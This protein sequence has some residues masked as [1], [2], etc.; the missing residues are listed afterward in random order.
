MSLQPI[1]VLPAFLWKFK[2][3]LVQTI[4]LSFTL[5]LFFFLGFASNYS[6]GPLNRIPKHLLLVDFNLKATDFN[7]F[8]VKLETWKVFCYILSWH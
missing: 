1:Y 3:N 6:N 8:G 7:W 4:V 2:R 5:L